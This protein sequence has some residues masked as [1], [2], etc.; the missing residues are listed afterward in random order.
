MAKTVAQVPGRRTGTILVGVAVVFA[1]LGLLTDQWVGGVLSAAVGI[2]G[3]VLAGK[4]SNDITEAMTRIS[5]A[6][7][8]AV[9][10]LVVIAVLAFRAGGMNVLSGFV[11]LLGMVMCGVL[12]VILGMLVKR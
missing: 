7:A 10:V 5:W 3:A 2:P 6:L 4:P 8:G 9:P 11:A 1:L 12:S